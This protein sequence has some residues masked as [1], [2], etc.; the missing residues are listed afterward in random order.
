M[1][2]DF[3]RNLSPK[4]DQTRCFRAQLDLSKSLNLPVI[5]HD[6]EAHKETLSILNEEKAWETGGVIHCFSGDIKMA[7]AC[8]DMGFY[9]SIPGTVTFNNAKTLHGVVKKVPLKNLLIET[10][11]PFLAPVPFRG[12]RNEPA[13]VKLVAEKI[14]QIKNISPE[15]VAYATTK[16]AKTLFS[17]P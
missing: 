11:A 5:I 2:L 15:E 9:I 4:E 7:T 16:N 13:H 3:F 17:L 6:R 14:A 8:V 1:G 10:D 12:K